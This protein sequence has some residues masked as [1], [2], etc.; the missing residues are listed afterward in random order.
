M[1]HGAA[2]TLALLASLGAGCASRGRL[3]TLHGK[4]ALPMAAA[5]P[6]PAAPG[7]VAA[8]PPEP[9]LAVRALPGDCLWNLSRR[10]LGSGFR[11]PEIAQANHLDEPWTI[12]V[13]QNI[14]VPAGARPPAASG[15]PARK[16]NQRYGWKAVPNTAFTLGEKLGYA[17]QYGSVTAGYA[18]LSVTEVVESQGRPVFHIVA[19]ARTHPFFETFFTVRDE[20]DSYMDVESA[21]SWRFEKHIQEGRFKSEASYEL[22]QRCGEI[23]EPAK[24]TLAPMPI[25]S[26]DVLSCLYYFRTQPM[27][28]GSPVSVTVT[29]DDMKNYV[30]S[31]DVLRKERVSTLAGDFDCVLVQPHLTFDGVFLHRGEVLIWI[32]DDQRRIPAL[33]RGT[34]GIGSINITLQDAEWV[35]PEQGEKDD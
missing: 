15:K 17:V 26:Q 21:F 14:V 9:R 27:V 33:I 4:R 16:E 25:G 2:L 11:W 32:T 10:Y 6:L 18:T 20:L 34:I 12:A 1:R 30:I 22:D 5:L 3:I 23:R 28:I 8:A 29:A 31:V 13:G 24:G 19:H 7:A 35:E